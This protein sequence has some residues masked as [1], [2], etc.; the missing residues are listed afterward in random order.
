MVTCCHG[1]ANSSGIITNRGKNLIEDSDYVKQLTNS[2][3]QF[4]IGLGKDFMAASLTNNASISKI[5]D[6]MILET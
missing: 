6:A 2:V 3:A 5:L 4:Q 1:V